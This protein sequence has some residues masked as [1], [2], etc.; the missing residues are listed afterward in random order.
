MRPEKRVLV[1][2]VAGDHGFAGAFNANIFKAA[3]QFSTPTAAKKSMSRPSAARRRD[4]FRRRYPAAVYS[5]RQVRSADHQM[6]ERSERKGASKLS[7]TIHMLVKLKPSA[8]SNWPRFIW[9]Y[10]HEEI[11]AAYIVYNEFKSVISQR[12]VAERLLPIIEIGKPTLPLRSS[13]LKQNAK[14]GRGGALGGHRDRSKPTL[15]RPTRNRRSSA[16]QKS[17]TSTRSRTKSFS[18]ACCR[19]TFH[20]ML[21]T[22][23]R[24]RCRGTCGPYDRN[25]LGDQQCNGHDRRLHAADEPPA[26]GGDYQGNH[27]D[28]ERRGC[29]VAGKLSVVSL[30]RLR[31]GFEATVLAVEKSKQGR[32]GLQQSQKRLARMKMMTAAS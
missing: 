6:T 24:I 19:S 31:I 11:D 20:A 5:E 16:P 21:F 1:I 29:V 15:Q 4:Q 3:F 30:A 14:R 2:V 27:R 22:P 17:T 13:R 18:T 28:C 26:P 25:G 7:A 23:W 12:L 32:Y 10:V 8:S 9:R